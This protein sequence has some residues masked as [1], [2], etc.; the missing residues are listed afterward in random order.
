MRFCE[1]VTIQQSE[2]LPIIFCQPLNHP[3][4]IPRAANGGN[5]FKGRFDQETLAT[6]NTKIHKKRSDGETE[7]VAKASMAAETKAL[8]VRFNMTHSLRRIVLPVHRDP[9]E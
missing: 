7:T 5:R 6:K 1:S 9:D 8:K 2:P 4:E 3:P